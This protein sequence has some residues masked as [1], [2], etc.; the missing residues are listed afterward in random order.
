MFSRVIRYHD[1]AD[2]FIIKHGILS[3]T[4]ISNSSFES[5]LH[6]IYT[7]TKIRLKSLINVF[8]FNYIKWK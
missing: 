2:A 7:F 3:L 4:S 8:K 1:L 6:S 5:I